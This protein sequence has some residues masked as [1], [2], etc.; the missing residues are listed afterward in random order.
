[1]H[2]DEEHSDHGDRYGGADFKRVAST[3]PNNLI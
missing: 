2:A 1:V 3:Y